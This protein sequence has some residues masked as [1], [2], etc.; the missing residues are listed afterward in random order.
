MILG[1]LIIGIVI[2]GVY[3][4]FGGFG[5]GESADS[6]EFET[7]AQ[8]VS[9]I[10]VPDETRI[11]ALG[12]ATHGNA[13]FQQLKLEVFQN[14]VANGGVRSFALEADFACCEK[15]NRYSGEGRKKMRIRKMLAGF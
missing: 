7:Y 8:S 12:E 2:G 11:I 5:S 15:V 13:E 4:N 10:T 1:I 3:C 9:E 14:M 6:T